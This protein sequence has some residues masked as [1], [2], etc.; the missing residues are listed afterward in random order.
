MSSYRAAHVANPLHHCWFAA[1]EPPEFGTNALLAD[2]TSGALERLL[3]IDA[4]LKLGDLIR[5]ANVI[6]IDGRPQNCTGCIRDDDHGYG[7]ARADSD[8]TLW[9]A[10]QRGQESW[11]TSTYVAPPSLRISLGPTRIR[12]RCSRLARCG[13]RGCLPS[14]SMSVRLV[15]LVPTS[16]PSKRRR[17][18]P[19]APAMR[20]GQTEDAPQ[21]HERD[22]QHAHGGHDARRSGR[23]VQC[24]QALGSRGESGALGR[25]ACGGV[26]TAHVNQRRCTVLLVGMASEW[27]LNSNVYVGAHTAIVHPPKKLSALEATGGIHLPV[28]ATLASANLPVVALNPRQ[29]RDLAKTTGKLAKTDRINAQVLAH[30]AEACRPAVRSLLA[31]ATQELALVGGSP[32]QLLEMRVAEQNRSRGAPPPHPLADP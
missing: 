4:R 17:I 12:G 14:R 10:I 6:L 25:V 32:R 21:H 31:A 13:N 8:D 2:G 18:S 30:F 3:C 15:A 29:V 26:L 19:P 16:M 22:D 20:R 1:A 28:L 27:Q 23:A 11:H 5:G 24:D 7:A 9:R